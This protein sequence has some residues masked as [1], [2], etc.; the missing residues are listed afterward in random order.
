M[1]QESFSSAD[2]NLPGTFIPNDL[3]QKAG[4]EIY[5]KYVNLQQAYMENH[6][7]ITLYGIDCNNLDQP[8]EHE[9]KTTTLNKL[10]R[11]NVNVDWITTTNATTIT[12]KVIISTDINRLNKSIEWIDNVFIPMNKSF[13][14]RAAT[15]FLY[16]RTVE[17]RRYIPKSDDYTTSLASNISDVTDAT[18]S[19]KFS[20]AWTQPISIIDQAQPKSSPSPPTT[21]N[22]LSSLTTQLESLT[23][24]VMD[25]QEKLTTVQEQQATIASEAVSKA[26]TKHS[27][28]TDEKYGSILL[29]INTQLTTLTASLSPSQAPSSSPPTTPPRTPKIMSSTSNRLSTSGNTTK[30]IR[31]TPTSSSSRVRKIPRRI[32]SHD[33]NSLKSHPISTL[34]TQSQTTMDIEKKHND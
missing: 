27:K 16:G 21:S 2:I 14:P 7:F 13:L 6:R 28:E 19:T 15:S 10:F 33:I 1:L 32:D 23:T 22:D 29:S 5:K 30:T 20:N 18:Y 24:M 11:E 4:H 25:L 31:S 9:N 26:I 17:R 3:S 34:Y 12:G 8:I